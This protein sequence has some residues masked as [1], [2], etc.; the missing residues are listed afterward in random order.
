MEGSVSGTLGCRDGT[1]CAGEH[2]RGRARLRRKISLRSGTHVGG[3]RT[4]IVG[5]G[6]ICVEDNRLVR[7]GIDGSITIPEVAMAESRLN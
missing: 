1:F 4:F 2:S 6:P 3:T 7:I 5:I